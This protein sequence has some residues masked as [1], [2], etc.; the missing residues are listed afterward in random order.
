M[1]SDG[2]EA[3]KQGLLLVRP[4]RTAASLRL[5]DS[6]RTCVAVAGRP[7]GTYSVMDSTE[8]QSIRRRQAPSSLAEPTAD[9]LG[10]DGLPFA[11][12][13]YASW[14]AASTGGSR[15]RTLLRRDHATTRSKL[16]VAVMC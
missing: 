15:C 2:I 7:Q 10:T 6:D 14:L 5:E 12:L 13:E 16:A 8:P 1:Q 9:N 11:V 4:M 3:K